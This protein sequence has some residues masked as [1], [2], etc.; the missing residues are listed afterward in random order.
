M[1]RQAFKKCRQP[2]GFVCLKMIFPFAL[3]SGYAGLGKEE[4]VTE[5][6]SILD[7]KGNTEMAETYLN[8]GHDGLGKAA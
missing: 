7:T 4:I 2:K 1:R 3:G 8:C 5:V 6:V